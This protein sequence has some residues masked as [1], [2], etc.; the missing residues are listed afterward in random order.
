MK[1]EYFSHEE[2]QCP[3]THVVKLAPS[4]GAHLDKL[5]M[6]FGKPMLVNSCCRSKAHNEYIGGHP[7]SLH[8]YDD[9]YHKTG[10]TMAIDISTNSY[11]AIEKVRLINLAWQ[12]NWSIGVAKNFIHLD[13][14]VDI[15]LPEEFYVY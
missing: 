6:V 2:L 5:R 8:V 9:P 15:G 14:R 12:H 10:G 4:F 7:R 3:S 11:L 1:L 13:R